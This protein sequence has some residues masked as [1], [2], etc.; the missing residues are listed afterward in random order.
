MS[1]IIWGLLAAV[2][3]GVSDAVAR[4][5]TQKVS[6]SILILA[7]MSLSTVGLS[8]LFIV[9]DDWPRWHAYAWSMS[10]ASGALNLVALMFLY[11]AIERGPVA[12]ASPAASSFT[13]MLVAMNAF[14]GQPVSLTQVLAIVLVFGGVIMLSRPAKSPNSEPDYDTAWLRTT[15]L[16]GL[17]TAFTVALRMF[18]A[19]EASAELGPMPALYLNRLFAMVCVIMLVA[20]QLHRG[21]QL[22]TPKGKM[23]ALVVAQSILEVAALWAFLV[24]SQ[25]D[26]RVAASIGFA[27]F[28]AITTITAWLWLGEKVPPQRWFWITLVG[29]GIMLASV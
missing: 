23:A 16:L 21:Q 8:L 9:T 2:F 4:A 1:G 13:V 25:G 28:A 11:K 24:G 26:G 5:T 6:I 7:V 27:A 20:W 10:A 29:L 15:A 17:A 3:I 19:Q 22:H 12:V 18:F 14:A